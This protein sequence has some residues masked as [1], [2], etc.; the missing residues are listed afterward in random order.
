MSLALNV[1]R[2]TELKYLAYVYL[3]IEHGLFTIVMSVE[4]L[5]Q[6]STKKSKKKKSQISRNL[7]QYNHLQNAIKEA[8]ALVAVTNSRRMECCVFENADGKALLA[9]SQ[10]KFIEYTEFPINRSANK[11]CHKNGNDQFMYFQYNSFSIY[12]NISFYKNDVHR[13]MNKY[14]I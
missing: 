10:R 6:S 13:Y 1:L 14:V 4:T 12:S 11:A 8:N 9:E 7:K 5:L 3:I 2:K